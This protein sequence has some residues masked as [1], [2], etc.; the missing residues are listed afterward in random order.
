MFLHTSA[1]K[2]R[3]P[4]RTFSPSRPAAFQSWV[5]IR[6]LQPCFF[7]VAS[8]SNPRCPQECIKTEKWPEAS[9]PLKPQNHSSTAGCTQMKEHRNVPLDQKNPRKTPPKKH[10]FKIKIFL[11]QHKHHLLPTICQTD[12]SG[13]IGV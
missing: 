13:H 2:S 3:Q 7:C 6:V 8:S 1:R 9:K 11:S 10:L 5:N 12:I 4:T